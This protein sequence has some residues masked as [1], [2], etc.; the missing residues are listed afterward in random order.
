MARLQS[1]SFLSIEP[2]PMGD[3]R[4]RTFATH[5]TF[6]RPFPICCFPVGDT[7]RITAI[8]RPYHATAGL[9]NPSLRQ[10]VFLNIRGFFLRKR[11]GSTFRAARRLGICVLEPLAWLRLEPLTRRSVAH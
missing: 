8:P 6:S 3:V 2:M 7:H 4:F 5:T 1:F 10:R 9:G 11:R